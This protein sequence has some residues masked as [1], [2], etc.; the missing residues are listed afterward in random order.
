LLL[1]IFTVV[2]PDPLSTLIVAA[3][4]QQDVD[5][6]SDKKDKITDALSRQ[7]AMMAQQ[8]A[9][10]GAGYGGSTLFGNGQV[11]PMSVFDYL[12]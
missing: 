11:K 6:L 9:L 8:Y 3:A 4:V 12:A 5:K 10:A 2:E 1:S 7:A